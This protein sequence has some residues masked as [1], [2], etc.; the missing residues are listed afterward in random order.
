MKAPA[1]VASGITFTGIFASFWNI[2]IFSSITFIT[3]TVFF[4]LLPDIDQVRSPVGKL[5][6]P[7]SKFLSKRYGHRTFTHSLIFL[8]GITLISAFIE[9]LFSN[10]LELTMVIFFAIFSHLILDM[11]TVQGIAFFYPFKRNPCVIPA[12]PSSRLET[13]NAKSEISIVA[14]SLFL[15]I[16]CSSLIN[17]GFWTTYNKSFGTILHAHKENMRQ[18]NLIHCNYSIIK[19][20]K[21]INSS[22]YII[23]SKEYELLLFNE[24][25][26][27]K[28]LRKDNFTKIEDITFNPTKKPK[29]TAHFNFIGINSDS[30]QQLFSDKIILNGEIQAS[31]KVSYLKNNI[32]KSSKSIKFK[33]TYNPSFT[34]ISKD[35]AKTDIRNRIQLLKLQLAEENKKHQRLS[36]RLNSLKNQYSE[37]QQIIKETSN[38]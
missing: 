34:I 19:N 14:I 12:N 5:F 18:S 9:K 7:I 38:L 3:V 22:G 15:L 27:L 24:K 20:G 31:Q 33:N 13:A 6:L 25:N 32:I 2:N 10:Q 36:K 29:K 28:W 35:T 8:S 1:H 4:S 26:G 30:I 11:I 37:V 17:Q 23:Q 21:E 16:S